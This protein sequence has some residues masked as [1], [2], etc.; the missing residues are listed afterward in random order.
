M[1]SARLQML[2]AVRWLDLGSPDDGRVTLPVHEAL[3]EL[4]LDDA[5]QVALALMAALGELEEAGD[6]AVE[7]T[8]GRATAVITL[9]ERLRRDVRMLSPDG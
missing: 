6:V 5:R 3:E 7:W 9:S 4:G 1:L 8:H 2:L